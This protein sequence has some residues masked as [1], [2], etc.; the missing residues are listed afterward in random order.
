MLTFFFIDKIVTIR[1]LIPTPVSDPS[2]LV[3]CQPVFEKFNFVTS[4]R[5]GWPH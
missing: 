4:R 2:G 1:T 5:C 3:P